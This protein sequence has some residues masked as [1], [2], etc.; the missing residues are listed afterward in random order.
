MQNSAPVQDKESFP[1]TLISFCEVLVACDSIYRCNVLEY[2]TLVENTPDPLK[3]VNQFG[4]F[5]NKNS[6][7]IRNRNIKRMVSDD[8]YL[9]ITEGP[10]YNKVFDKFSIPLG[11]IMQ[12]SPKSA[13]K[14]M[15]WLMSCIKF[16]VDDP[17]EKSCLMESLRK[18]AVAAGMAPAAG[19][20][21]DMT[22]GPMAAL[23]NRAAKSEALTSLFKKGSDFMENEENVEMVS[24]MMK[25]SLGKIFGEDAQQNLAPVAE[26][27]LPS[28]SNFFKEVSSG[29]ADFTSSLFKALPDIQKSLSGVDVS[30][31]ADKFKNKIGEL[32]DKDGKLDTQKVTS[33]LSNMIDTLSP[34]QEQTK[35]LS[36]KIRN[37][38]ST[39]IMNNITQFLGEGEL[40]ADNLRQGIDRLGFE[41]FIAGVT[42][43]AG[44]ESKAGADVY[45]E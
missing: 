45:L 9:R 18:Q 1:D 30:S 25:D 20:F 39:E 5:Y 28:F 42:N 33:T 24:S 27:V 36:D 44:K 11:K 2:K 14:V 40:T 32:Q 13:D 8:V 16:S 35:A 4:A 41:E 26:K 37:C 29:D 21:G 15:Y 34:D 23:L 38:D 43:N 17:D 12:E 22:N 19:A 6:S 10:K 3:Y 7:I 31:L